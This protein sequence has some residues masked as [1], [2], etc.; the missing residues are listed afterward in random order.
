MI[1]ISFII[2]IHH[3][4]FDTLTAAVAAVLM[5]CR[6]LL[7]LLRLLL[8]LVLLS[9]ITVRSDKERTSDGNAVF[10]YKLSGILTGLNTG[11]I[12]ASQYPAVR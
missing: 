9:H 11:A 4:L 1:N 7:L 5:R 10:Y 6:N 8:R 2:L 12:V 3:A